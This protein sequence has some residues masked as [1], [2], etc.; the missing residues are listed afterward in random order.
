M[1]KIMLS[2]L[3]L[4]LFA[5]DAR[6]NVQTAWNNPNANMAPGSARPGFAQL[7]WSPGTV[8]P[9]R[10]R[11]GMVTMINLPMGE[12][13]EDA[14]VGNTGLFQAELQG[15]GRTIMLTPEP[16]NQGSDTNLIVTGRSGNVYLFYLRSEPANS[17]EIS[18]SKVDITLD[19]NAHM[20]M[21]GGMNAPQTGG[22]NS[23]F[24]RRGAGGGV[25]GLSPAGEDFGWIQTMKIDPSEF[26][27]DLDIFVPNPD[28]YVIAPERV[29]RDRIFTYIDFGDKV[30]AMT[31]RPVVSIL[32]EGGESPVGFRTDG[33]HGRLIIVEA[34]GDMVLR[35]GQRLVCIKKRSRPFLV[36]DTASVMRLAE[37]NVMQSMFSNQSLNNVVFG[38]MPM[39]PAP[40]MVGH[41]MMP[42]MGGGMPM[43]PM[44][45]QQPMMMPQQF[46]PQGGGGGRGMNM[47]PQERTTAGSFLPQSNIPLIRSNQ[48]GVA[49]ELRSDTSVKALNDYWTRLL[50]QFSG[51]EGAGLLNPYRDMVFFAV[52]EQGVGDLGASGNTARLY[53]LRIGPLSNIDEAQVL[54]DHL[55]RFRSIPCHVVR[56]Q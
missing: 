2:V 21:A 15:G 55:Q 9:I 38:G 45:P 1:K 22:M 12:V 34:V 16:S 11:S 36:A 18:Y 4:A 3:C 28:D 43:M 56:V 48:V 19:G 44:Q 39:M 33:E 31:Q 46:A 53:R 10:L 50:A 23:L 32:I 27:F 5:P 30:I 52:D 51:D 47:I 24:P 35:S 20:P 14:T 40:G 54:C 49:V 8:M 37:A 17:P 41:P 25:G 42:G 26:R 6:A 13:V 29:W 7:T